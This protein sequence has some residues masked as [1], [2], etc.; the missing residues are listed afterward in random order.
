M[1]I[2]DIEKAIAKIKA[3]AD[4]DEMA[5]V[6]EDELYAAFIGYVAGGGS[7]NLS[8]KAKLVLSTE[9]ISFS[10]WCA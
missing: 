1:T 9:D 6:Y 4:D 8:E 5:H 7:D 10:R 3:A 2:N